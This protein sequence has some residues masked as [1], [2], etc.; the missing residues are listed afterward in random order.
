MMS[1]LSIE[2]LNFCE[3]DLPEESQLK[4]QGSASYFDTDF[5]F[6]WDSVFNPS[7]EAA[8]GWTL[9]FGVAIGDTLAIVQT[10]SN[11]LGNR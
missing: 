4:L 5:D 3:R 11:A 9:A 6:N 2:D 8:A 1:Q 7:G 10:L